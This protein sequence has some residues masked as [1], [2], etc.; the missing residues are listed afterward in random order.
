MADVQSHNSNGDAAT[1]T[2]NNDKSSSKFKTGRSLSIHERRLERQ[3]SGS[4]EDKENLDPK[5]FESTEATTGCKFPPDVTS[6]RL[7]SANDSELSDDVEFEL[8]DV[9]Q[10]VNNNHDGKSYGEKKDEVTENKNEDD[11]LRSSLMDAIRNKRVIS[12]RVTPL[13][14]ELCGNDC[15]CEEP[16]LE[17][18]DYEYDDDN[19][20]EENILEEENEV[21]V[22]HEQGIEE[23]TPKCIYDT[24][25]QLAA[26][27]ID[28]ASDDD[29]EERLTMRRKTKPRTLILESDN[30][31]EEEQE[32]TEDESKQITSNSI[33]SDNVSI[34]LSDDPSVNSYSVGSSSGGDGE[35]FSTANAIEGEAEEEEVRSVHSDEPI[36]SSWNKSQTKSKYVHSMKNVDGCENQVE[37]GDD[38]SSL[39][40]EEW[41]ELSS[42]DEEEEERRGETVIILSSDE[43]DES[44]SEHDQ[45]SAITASD[46]SESDGEG[47]ARTKTPR[48]NFK[49]TKPTGT[50][51]TLKTKTEVNSKP[52]TTAKSSLA[53][54]KNR[55]ALTGET[56]S[57]FN[58][59]AFQNALSSVK[60][61]WSKKLN[62]T[63]GITRMRGKLGSEHV[64]TRVATIELATKVIDNEERLRSTLL[65]EMCHAMAWLVDGVHKPPHGRCFK[66]WAGIAMKQV[67]GWGCCRYCLDLFHDYM[68]VL[69]T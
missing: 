23:A 37:L 59:R 46:E 28:Y 17:I 56:F 12:L 20:N 34:D 39:S 38:K 47:R 9:E 13:V 32:E 42:D 2:T 54:R 48:R 55:D 24:V 53:F 3:F 30:D 69:I 29:S 65:H 64:H 51:V 58:H 4:L 5:S 61:E 62:T 57:E 26:T 14:H 67:R 18:N 21:V 41:V 36:S 45:T 50:H 40:E 11:K 52:S 35:K 49:V 8:D 15:D 10:D 1:V 66:K 7:E 25:D 22:S 6:S 44:E 43:E 63:A 27:A 19:D 60:V 16:I 31:D 68:V 33:V